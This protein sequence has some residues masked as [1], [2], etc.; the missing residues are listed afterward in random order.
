M[1]SEC[2]PYF[3]SRLRWTQPHA[4]S[5][6]WPNFKQSTKNHM[7]C[8]NGFHSM[9]SLAMSPLPNKKHTEWTTEWSSQGRGSKTFPHINSALIWFYFIVGS[10]IC[11]STYRMGL[12]QSEQWLEKDPGCEGCYPCI[13]LHT[14]VPLCWIIMIFYFV[15][16]KL[17]MEPL[18]GV[19]MLEFCSFYPNLTPFYSKNPKVTEIEQWY[20]SLWD[21]ERHQ[22][23]FGTCW[24]PSK[25]IICL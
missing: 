12:T 19:R 22:A 20:F 17:F 24:F 25:D 23:A 21:L 4:D 14:Q 16:I 11:L 7:F 10:I 1:Y 18:A 9:V 8:E 5:I 6:S 3:A 2:F 13:L 15:D